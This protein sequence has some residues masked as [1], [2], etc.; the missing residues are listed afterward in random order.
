MHSLCS[1]LTSPALLVSE[2]SLRSRGRLESQQ[3][4]ADVYDQA[5]AAL[6]AAVEEGA[7][8]YEMP[9][10]TLSSL[11]NAI[12]RKLYRGINILMLR[13][14]AQKN[15]T[16]RPNEPPIGSGANRALKCAKA[17]TAHSIIPARAAHQAMPQNHQPRLANK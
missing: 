3:A 13:A 7:G 8:A 15:N 12:S 5:T 2:C 10:H 14:A 11:I 4:K 17:S 6:V 9:W 16:D 1:G